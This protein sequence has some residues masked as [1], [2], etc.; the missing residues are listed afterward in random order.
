MLNRYQPKLRAS[1]QVK[2]GIRVTFL[3]RIYH[4][5][6]KPKIDSRRLNKLTRIASRRMLVIRITN[7]SSVRH[8]HSKLTNRGQGNR[9]KIFQAV[10]TRSLSNHLNNFNSY[11]VNNKR[12]NLR[13]SLPRIFRLHSNQAAFFP[14]T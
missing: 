7:P 5:G 8:D 14:S 3:N 13:I 2:I 11:R 10:T 4:K 6:F 12:T 9:L 1:R